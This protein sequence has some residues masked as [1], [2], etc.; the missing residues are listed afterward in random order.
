MA[1]DL[2]DSIAEVRQMKKDLDRIM[3][4]LGR[5]GDSGHPG[6][7]AFSILIDPG[8][9]IGEA[10]GDYTTAVGTDAKATTFGATAYGFG[11]EATTGTEP[12]AVGSN[13]HAEGLRASAV[14]RAAGATGERS[15][16]VGADSDA[17]SLYA[18]TVGAEATAEASD[19][20]ALGA[21]SHAYHARSVAVGAGTETTADD[22]V[23]L[24]N[25]DQTVV[26]P[27]TF[28]N[29]SARRLKQ[30][31]VPAPTLRS[32]FPTQY[33]WEY[34]PAPDAEVDPRRRISPMAD[35]LLGTD[36]ERFVT[37]DNDGDVA[38]IA[39]I[40]LLVAQVGVLHARVTALENTPARRFACWLSTLL[41]RRNG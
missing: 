37:F 7:G 32:I 17:T 12:T 40:E 36:A 6:S 16:A 5:G 39:Y 4:Q 23:M 22:Q 41:R 9:G 24:G 34:I 18:T 31:I 35:D 10:S 25:S 33:E 2:G 27:G 19:S 20:T 30:N 13:A 21:Y 28:S 3:P 15:T 14:G 8:S 11:A 26:V 29:P 38:G 1:D